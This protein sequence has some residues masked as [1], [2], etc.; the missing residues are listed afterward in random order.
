MGV[1][2]PENIL[3]AVERG[4]DFFDCVLPARNGR[5]GHLFTRYGKINIQNAR[6]ERDDSPIDPSCTC[7]VCIKYSRAYLRHLF[8]AKEILALRLAVLHN[9]HFYNKLMREIRQAIEENRFVT[10][11]RQ[12]LTD[13]GQNNA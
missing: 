13:F 8:K 2:T 5:H 1:G 7:P 10:Y 9:L 3:E 11:K 4:I 12:F 6:Y